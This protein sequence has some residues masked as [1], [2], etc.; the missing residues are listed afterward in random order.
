MKKMKRAVPKVGYTPKVHVCSGCGYEYN[1]DFGDENADIRVGTKFNDLP[2]DW[3]CPECGE[4]K[5][6]L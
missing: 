3:I 4:E 2:E 6:T 1:P 5:I